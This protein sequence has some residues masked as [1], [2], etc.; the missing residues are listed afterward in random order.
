VP[1]G[2]QVVFRAVGDAVLAPTAEKRRAFTTVVLRVGRPHGLFGFG[3]ADTHGH[4]GLATL[5]PGRFVHDAKLALASALG[6]ELVAP[7]VSEIRDTW[8]AEAVIGYVHRQDKKHKSD[9]DPLREG[10]SLHALL[11]LQPDGV[12]IAER[13][14][15]LAPRLQRSDLLDQLGA[16]SLAEEV[17]LDT[18]ADAAAGAVGVATLEGRSEEAVRARLAAVHAAIEHPAVAVA[19]ALGV[20]D[21]A[22]RKLRAQE[23]EPAMVRAIRLQMGLRAAL[24]GK[25]RVDFLGGD[26]ES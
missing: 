5:S 7:A 18:L 20:T 2:Y 15:K 1:I 26:A 17:H 11:G 14:R 4:A 12:W 25:A 13:V 8:H 3:V 24:A 9:L 6:V 22:V 10:T 16:R 21:R 23:P 19:R